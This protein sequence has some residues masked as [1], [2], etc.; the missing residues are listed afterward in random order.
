VIVI[1]NDYYYEC[2]SNI[3]FPSDS[4]MDVTERSEKNLGSV[5][6]E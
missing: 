3:Q 1:L 6:A 2:L 5:A 4:V